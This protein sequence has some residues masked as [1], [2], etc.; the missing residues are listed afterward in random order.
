M[1]RGAMQTDTTQRGVFITFEGGDGAGTT[2]HMGFLAKALVA[3][4]REVVRLRE[5]GGT[6]IGEELRAVV[7]DPAN[8]AMVDECELLVYEAARAQLVAQ[9]IKPALARGAVVLCDRFTDSTLAYQ[10]YGRGLDPSIIERAN[11]FAC[12][13]V[14]PD[15][16]VLMLTGGGASVGLDRATRS[17]DA[18]RL[19][20]AGDAFHER[21]LKGYLELADRY[22]DRI[23]TVVS[24]DTKPA[25]AR[26]VFAS[27]VDVLEC[28]RG[29]LDDD[30]FFEGI[31]SFDKQEG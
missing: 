3:Q 23:R 10:A 1:K 31:L 2:T 22:P 26:K 18:D 19:E 14:E 16:T 12:Q 5:P 21:V 24:S 4:G 20:L 27:V 7:L 15:R 30:A 17:E 6:A 28:L 11:D 25:T 8:V 29:Y 9:E 13:G